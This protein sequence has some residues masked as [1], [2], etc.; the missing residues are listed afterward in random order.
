MCVCVCV[1]VSV[2]YTL[3]VPRGTNKLF[4]PGG[5][6]FL[7]H[8]RKGGTTIFDTQGGDKHFMLEAVVAMMMFMERWMRAKRAI[9][10]QE[11]GP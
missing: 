7:T 4:V 6:T 11:L 2:R 9:S 3:F 1:C 5:Q 10:P 8:R